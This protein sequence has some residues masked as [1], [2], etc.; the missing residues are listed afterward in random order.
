[1]LAQLLLNHPPRACAQGAPTGDAM[2]HGRKL[3]IVVAAMLAGGAVGGI[4]PGYA[5]PITVHFTG[6]V[7]S[8]SAG[9]ASGFSVGD[10]L[11]GSYTFESGTAARGGSTSDFAAFDA[12]TGLSFTVNG[13]AASSNGAPELQVDDPPG[14]PDRYGLVARASDGL[15][16]AD[17][18]GLSLFNF[19]F[20]LDDSTGTAFA[21]ALLLPSSLSLAD[22]DS[23]SFFLFFDGFNQLVSG[24]ITGISFVGVPEPALLALF[25][26]SVLA[27]GIAARRRRPG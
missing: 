20:R 14:G 23:T 22:F 18:N 26:A 25:G 3:S 15:T 24:S 12:L 6:T 16:G 13:Y 7:S 27:A 2:K 21:D 10:A 19:G 4:A 11:A 8:V 5:A 1:M 17:V 9:V